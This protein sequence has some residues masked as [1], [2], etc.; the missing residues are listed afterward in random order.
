M[1]LDPK[2]WTT[3]TQQAVATALESARANSNPEVTPDHL[4]AALVGQEDSIVLP[5][6]QK[7]GLAPLMVR[8][9]A[10]EAV[11]RLPKAYGTSEPHMSRETTAAFETAEATRKE[12]RDDYL[13]A[14]HLLLAL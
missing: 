14:E 7:L 9:S 8:N 2:K 13:S 10:D 6:L 12:L 11:N 5:V 4:L 1:A 3:K